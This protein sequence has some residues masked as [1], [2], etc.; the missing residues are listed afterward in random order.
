MIVQ[1]RPIHQRDSSSGAVDFSTVTKLGHFEGKKVYKLL[2]LQ[3]VAGGRGSF[4][5]FYKNSSN[6]YIFFYCSS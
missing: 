5:T 1:S 3:T 6:I 4:P 2:N